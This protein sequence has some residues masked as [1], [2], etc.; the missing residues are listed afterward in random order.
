MRSNPGKT[1]AIYEIPEFITH[2]QLNGLTQQN[3][4]SGFKNTGI[5]PYNRDIFSNLDYATDVPTQQEDLNPEDGNLP[6]QNNQEDTQE[7]TTSKTPSPKQGPLNGYVSPSDIVP[8]PK[9]AQRKATNRGRKRVNTKI[10][11]N[12]P[13][14]NSIAENV[15]SKQNTKRKPKQL[16]TPKTKRSLFE[17]SRKMSSSSESDRRQIRFMSYKRVV[18]SPI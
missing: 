7:A 4:V 8:L 12:T 17:A 3:Y 5:F 16:V 6:H 2:G 1:V 10:L 18:Y 13:V 9:V 15:L 11:T 14:K